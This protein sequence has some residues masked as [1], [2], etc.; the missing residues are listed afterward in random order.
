MEEMAEL[1]ALIGELRPETADVGLLKAMRDLREV[2]SPRQLSV[3]GG[4]AYVEAYLKIVSAVE[5]ATMSVAACRRKLH[6]AS[7]TA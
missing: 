5:A 2:S 4:D 7:P 6:D 3:A 1:A